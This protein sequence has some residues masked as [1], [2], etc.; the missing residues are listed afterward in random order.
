MKNGVS[1]ADG[2]GFKESVVSK[3]DDYIFIT[4]C[5]KLSL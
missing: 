1:F 2:S 5:S 3:R 4:A